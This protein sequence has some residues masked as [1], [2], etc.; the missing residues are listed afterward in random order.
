LFFV[1]FIS[2][3]L[4]LGQSSVGLI[5]FIM[6]LMFLY[7]YT[8][9]GSHFNNIPGLY[10]HAFHSVNSFYSYQAFCFPFR[11]IGI[12]VSYLCVSLVGLGV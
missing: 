12:L 1:F 10:F 9:P 2:R 8:L 11:I 4:W 6:A 3:T 7:I 5:F